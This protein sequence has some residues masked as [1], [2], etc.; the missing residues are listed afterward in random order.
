[1]GELKLQQSALSTQ[2]SAFNSTIP[3]RF[4]GLLALYPSPLPSLWNQQWLLKNSFWSLIRVKSG[5]QKCLE[6]R[7]DRL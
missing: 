6:I 5:D 7:E 4:A 2:Q 3:L 1:M